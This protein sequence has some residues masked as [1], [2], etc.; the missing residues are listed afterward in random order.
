VDEAPTALRTPFGHFE[1]KRYPARRRESLRAWCAADILLL[2][3]ARRLSVAGA[4]TLVVNDDFGALCLALS[5]RGLWTDSS[6]AVTAL[7]R[8][9]S[10]NGA[11]ATPVTWA[12]EAPPAGAELVVLRVPKSLP[13]FHYQLATLAATLAPGTRLIAGGMDK[14]LSAHTAAAMEKWLG[15]TTRHRGERKARLFSATLSR[16]AQ[17]PATGADH[18]GVYHCEALGA[19]LV[20][21]PGVFS[22][23]AL[24]IGTRLLLSHLP[25]LAPADTVVDLACGN[26]VLGLAAFHAGLARQV[27]FCDESS[28]AIKSARDNAARLYPDAQARLEFLHGDGLLPARELRADLILCNPPFHHGHLVDEYTGRRLLAQCPGHMAPGGR[29]CLVANRHLRYRPLLSKRFRD[30]SRLTQ[31]DKFTVYLA[32]SPR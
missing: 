24:D 22:G 9:E 18:G 3:E 30:V 19:D 29:L 17:T 27:L 8:N 26:G 20:S 11:G 6:L 23:A 13:F 1:L 10:A 16:A 2:E 28:L 7:R 32:S 15:P 21:R 31:N 5:P 25:D 14:H 12:T 4:N